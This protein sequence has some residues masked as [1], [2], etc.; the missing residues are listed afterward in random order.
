M[1]V[2][3]SPALR[4]P[5]ESI[6]LKA[7]FKSLVFGPIEDL[8]DSE[9]EGEDRRVLTGGDEGTTDGIGDM[10]MDGAGVPQRLSK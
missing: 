9:A 10:E 5:D 3:E 4:D 8:G 7:L 2:S 6:R 1:L